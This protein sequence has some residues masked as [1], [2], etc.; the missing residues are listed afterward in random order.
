M[1]SL[2]H[3][4]PTAYVVLTIPEAIQL[5]VQLSVCLSVTRKI[6]T[7][8]SRTYVCGLW[9]GMARGTGGARCW[10]YWDRGIPAFSR[11]VRAKVY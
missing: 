2:C 5:S 7:A 6:K 8:S 3:P 9:G 11:P 10:G 4:I 1:K